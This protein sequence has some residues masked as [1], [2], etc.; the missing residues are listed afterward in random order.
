MKKFWTLIML[1]VFMIACK[2]NEVK[3]KAFTLHGEIDADA[4]GYIYMFKREKGQFITLDSTTVENREFTFKGEIDYPQ[5][6]YLKLSDSPEYISLFL[7]PGNIN[8]VINLQDQS[9]PLVSGSKSHDIYKTYQDDVFVFDKTLQ[10]IYTEYREA[11]SVPDNEARIAL[12]EKQYD[13]VEQL[14]NDYIIRYITENVNS[15]VSAFIALRNIYILDYEQLEK[16]S[17]GISPDLKTSTYVKDLNDRIEKLRNV[18]IGMK[19]P[20]FTMNDTTDAPVTLSSL[21]GKY[22]LID[23]WAS[24]CGPCRRENPNVVA[25]FQ[26]YKDKGFDILGVSLDRDREKWIE[27]IHADNLTWHHVSDLAYWNNEAAQLYSVSAIPSNV[28]LDPQGII[29]ARN[30]TGDDLQKKLVEIFE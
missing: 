9:N 19:A 10:G 29:I 11:A 17:S 12:I 6:T 26:K 23:F 21:L 24:W 13:S 25:A 16:I 7:E 15:P 5:F 3:D 14:K 22:M 1:P 30:I 2:T 20:D 28:L 4:A 18:Q 8:I 27:A